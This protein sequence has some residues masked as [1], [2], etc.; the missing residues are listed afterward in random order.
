MASYVKNPTPDELKTKIL[1]AISA[2]AE[3]G[4]IRKGVNETTKAIEKKTALLVVIAEDV[5]PEEIVIHLPILCEEKGIPYGFVTTKQELGEAAKLSV[6][7]SSIA[8]DDVGK[9]KELIEALRK[10]LGKKE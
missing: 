4:K 3:G 6:P 10:R 2:V 9:A 1:E 5:Q 8:I 7:T